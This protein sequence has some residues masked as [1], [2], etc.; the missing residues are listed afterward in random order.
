MVITGVKGVGM[1][2]EISVF[3]LLNVDFDFGN[4][5]LCSNCYLAEG[6]INCIY[7][8]TLQSRLH[9]LLRILDSSLW[10]V[11]GYCLQALG[12]KK[13]GLRE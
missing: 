13:V 11:L 7:F 6:S 8:C 10:K 5:L 12:L 2:F 1:I 4:A 3:D 9:S